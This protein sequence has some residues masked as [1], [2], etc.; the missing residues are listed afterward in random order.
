MKGRARKEA[1]RWLI[2]WGLG[3][4]GILFLWGPSVPADGSMGIAREAFTVLQGTQVLKDPMLQVRPVVDGLSAPTTM[5]FIGPDDLLVLQKDDGRVRRVLRGVLQPGQVLDVAVD[6]ASERG[7][8]GI[9]LHPGFPATPWVYLYYTESSMESDTSGSPPPL[10]N[11]VYRFIWDG[12]ALINPTLIL[13]LPA[14]PGPNHDGGIIAFGP[15]GK[16]Y[17]VIGDLNR[18]GQLQNFPAGPSPDDT[19]V[20]FRLNDDGS[21]PTDNPFFA[22]GGNLARYF[23]YGIRNSFGISFDPVTGKLWI[24]ENGPDRYD[25]INRVEAGFNGG[26]EPILGPNARDPQGIED[27]FLVPG[28]Q[29]VDPEFSWRDVVAPTGIVFLDSVQL[30]NQY[31]RDLLVGDF[32][33]GALYRFELNP[34]RDRFAFK[35]PGLADRVADSRSELEGLVFGTG[36]GGITDLK[37]GPDGLLYLLSST[38][39]KIFVVSRSSVG[40][41]LTGSWKMLNQDCRE[42]RTGVRCRVRGTFLVQ[43]QG[44]VKA[45]ASRLRFYQS[46]DT[47][48]DAGDRLL[49]QVA[50]GPLRPGQTRQRSWSVT[51][52]GDLGGSFVLAVVDAADTV[53]EIDETNNVIVFG[54]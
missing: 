17:G 14:T 42:F 37:V 36:F 50:A 40:P 6:N 32:N 29:Y 45:S 38:E 30:G 26:W 34:A 54:R 43:N 41:D 16:L 13:D 46:S 1:A 20:I 5:A 18:D 3:M 21:I 49:R 39:G 22:Q 15:D 28:A 52:R 9:A 48:F 25:E 44:T 24:T 35:H 23:A 31:Y 8:L 4:V 33:R 2:R 27:L 51:L 10:G 11:R 53:A 47:T 7:L 19:S 12:N